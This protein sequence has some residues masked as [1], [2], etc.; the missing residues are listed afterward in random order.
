MPRPIVELPVAE[1]LVCGILI[2]AFYQARLP[3]AESPYPHIREIFE[4]SLPPGMHEVSLQYE[5]D[6]A[7][8]V[9]RELT[10]CYRSDIV[11]MLDKIVDI[12]YLRADQLDQELYR[13]LRQS[14]EGR[15]SFRTHR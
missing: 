8:H 6:T 9:R 10:L 3:G 4:G 13:Y 11:P 12:R 7:D 2:S 5:A 14:I 15:I 1:R